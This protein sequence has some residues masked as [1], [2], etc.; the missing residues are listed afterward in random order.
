MH[1]DALLFALL[2]IGDLALIA[3]LRRRH[4]RSVRRSRMAESLRYAVRQ[5]THSTVDIGMR[6]SSTTAS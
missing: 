4:G 5:A 6:D 3:Y 1:T 2:A